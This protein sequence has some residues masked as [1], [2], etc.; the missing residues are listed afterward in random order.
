MLIAMAEGLA[1]AP[2]DQRREPP[3]FGT[4]VTLVAVPVFVTDK[5][6]RSVGGL[7]IE[8]F[9]IED[10][11][12]KV[13]IVSFQAI[14]VDAPIT[15]ESQ[16][17]LAA[18][19][20]AVQAAAPRQFLLLFDLGFSPTQ[21][22]I[23]GRAAGIAFVRDALAPGDLVA[24]AV[25]SRRG[26][27]VL[28]NFTTDRERAARAIEGLGLVGT[29]GAALLGES[30]DLAAGASGRLAAELAE[31]QVNLNAADQFLYK[32]T[33]YTFMDDLSQLVTMLSPLRGRKQVVLLS[34]GFRGATW[35]GDSPLL[36]RMNSLFQKAGLG[37][38][39]IHAVSLDGLEAGAGR[40]TLVH[41]AQSTGGRF[42]MPTNDFGVALGEVERIS[43]HSYVVAFEAGSRQARRASRGS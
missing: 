31:M 30:G 8:D 7:T 42:I 10:G 16:A 41:L 13:P 21:G 12:K 28:T 27:E 19:P 29:F 2:Q 5:S 20:V 37:D 40:D 17:E 35:R 1:A 38:V 4:G 14:D 11:G 39:V 43:R 36:G 15:P 22:I 6:G 3:V 32:Q 34:A 24:V 23:R 26:L 9:E 33:V 25:S 18:L